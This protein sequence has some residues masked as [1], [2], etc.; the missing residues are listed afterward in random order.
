M[1]FTYLLFAFS[2]FLLSGCD[3]FDSSTDYNLSLIP[4]QDEEGGD[5]GFINLNGD[6]I[7]KPDFENEP[8]IFRN[9]FS[10]VKTRKGFYDYINIEGEM[11]N[12]KYK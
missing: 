5:W 4:F 11:M 6:V 7:I 8:S 12:Q 2:V 9:G 10:L 3:L 1:K